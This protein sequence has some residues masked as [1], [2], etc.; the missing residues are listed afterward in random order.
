MKRS[1]STV[2][3]RNCLVSRHL[4]VGSDRFYVALTNYGVQ[5]NNLLFHPFDEGVTDLVGGGYLWTL[6][7]WGVSLES[8]MMNSTSSMRN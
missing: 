1:T 4:D 2:F 3:Y 6:I 8:H 5:N 7:L